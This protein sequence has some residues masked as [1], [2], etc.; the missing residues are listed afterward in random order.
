MTSAILNIIMDDLF[1]TDIC[2][3]VIF[4]TSKNAEVLD[5]NTKR[6]TEVSSLTHVN[7]LVN[8]FST[9]QGHNLKANICIIFLK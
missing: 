6:K 9:L 1:N 7:I 5:P 4:Q 2:L 8:T 3:V